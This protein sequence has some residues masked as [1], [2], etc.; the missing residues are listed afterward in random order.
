MKTLDLYLTKICNLDCEYCYVDVVK[1]ENTQFPVKEFIQRINLLDY[2][3]IKFFGGE[4]LVKWNMIQEIV[5]S[6][7]K[8]TIKPQFTIVTNGI[9]L[10]EAKIEFITTYN[11]NVIASIHE[12][13]F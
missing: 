5:L 11:I 1:K 10:D 6:V 8:E 9:L 13:S 7:Q 2:D 12:G 4:P 3:D